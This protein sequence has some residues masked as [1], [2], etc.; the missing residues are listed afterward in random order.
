MAAFIVLPF[1]VLLLASSSL[2]VNIDF[3]YNGFKSATN[4]SLDG[5]A[6]ITSNGVLQLTNDTSKVTG[7]AFF[8]S[9][10][11]MLRNT[12]SM[13]PTTISFSTIFVFDIITARK[14]GGHG[15]AFAV[16]PTKTLRGGCC[17]YLGLLNSSNNGNS[18]NHV[19][20]IEFDTIPKSSMLVD[21]HENEVGV[22]INSIVP[23]ISITTSYY[24]NNSK[25]VNFKLESGQ[26]IQTWINY[27]GVA[28]ILNVTVAPFSVGKP[29]RPLI[30]L[31]IDLSPILKKYMYV[32]FSSSTGEISSSHYILG[33]SFRANGMARS[34]DLSH[35]PLPPQPMKDS[36]TSKF[37]RIKIGVISSIAMLLLVALAFFVS[38]HLRQRAK[39]AETLEDWELDYP[40]RFAYKDL[41]KATK[42]FKET[43]LL[44][45]GGFGL[46]YKGTLPCSGEEVAVKKISSNSRQG[47]REFV[48]EV[49]CLGRMRHRNLVQLQGWCK[50][51]EEL[52]LV[53]ELMPNGSLD[54]FLFEGEKCGLLSWD[55]RFKI[56][57]GVALGLLYLHEEWE[58]V[59]V[60]RDIKSSNVLLD[61]DMNGRLGDFGLARLYDRGKNPHTTLMVG[62]FGYIAPEVS[63]TGKPMASSDVFAYGIL[64]LEVACGRRPIQH[65]APMEQLLLKDWVR[66][67]K[68][69]GQILEA[70]DPKLGESYVKEEVDLVL[71]LGLVCSQSIPEVRPTMRQVIQY[72][73]R[74]DSLADD[75]ALVFSEADF[76]DLASL[77]SYLSSIATV[78]SSSLSGGRCERVR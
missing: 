53:Y 8:S 12:R 73:N 54:T 7:H 61:A 9:P 29:S 38:W 55:Q 45:S 19:F 42:G 37:S 60:H 56:L 66:E 68:M 25:T 57:K 44:G 59:V 23:N 72:L 18:S 58:Q 65:D 16:A 21:I 4:L 46:V 62:T 13:T 63:R 52:L 3:T 70:V 30:S 15:L 71:K 26:P 76:L 10:I 47:V 14:V 11:Q 49:V 77:N 43:E 32:G 17:R 35:L 5:Y 34:L 75:V 33:W 20:A 22:D 40:H 64:L 28:K 24:A 2:S 50:R 27:D 1:L 69:R 78:S 36:P 31:P 39:L 41:Y 48:A 67:C 74:D 51:N 6:G